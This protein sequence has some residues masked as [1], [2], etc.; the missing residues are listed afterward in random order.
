M[1]NKF[2]YGLAFLSLVAVSCTKDFEEMNTNKKFP[3]EAPPQ[4]LFANAAK[5]LSRQVVTLNVNM[6]N[7]KLWSQ[8]LTQTT[9]TD[10]GNYLNSRNIPQR[11]WRQM[12]REILKDLNEAKKFTNAETWVTAEDKAA[13]QNRLAIMEIYEVYVYE[14]LTSVFGDVPYSQAHSDETSLPEYT[15]AKTV[16]TDLN[17]RLDAI[18]A[19]LDPAAGS[20]DNGYDNLFGGDVAM[21][22]K[23]V[24]GM[25]LKMAMTWADVDAAMAT[26]LVGEADGKVF[27]AGEGANFGFMPTAPN[28]NP[29]WEDL[30]NSG[31]HDY[32]AANTIVDT[33]NGL[34]DP[35]IGGYFTMAP[36]TN[37]YIGGIYG[38]SNS[39]SKFSHIAP[40]FKDPTQ[41]T[42]LMDYIEMEFYF[43]EA[44]ARGLGGGDAKTH[45]E[46]AI[47]ASIEMWAPGTDPS[48]YLA[49]PEVAYDAA[50][51]KE[52]IGL[53]AWLGFF[54]RG[55]LGWTSYRRLDHPTLNIAANSGSPTPKRYTYP[56]NEQTLNGA[57]YSAASAAIGGDDLNTPLWW[58]KN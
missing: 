13:Q 53:Q 49:L 8:Y 21:W 18:L 2:I 7:L 58:D 20:F 17:T 41:P 46:N 9:Y 38:G 35:R 14:R 56:V 33:M 22:T 32:V 37:I 15:D 30:V 24:Y 5:E 16:Y 11:E 28:T 43:A 1:K 6:N 51:W 19:K 44:A 52:Q 29:M 10:E 57:N 23:F 25:K 50:K 55:L 31:R 42:I 27:A 4:A 39:F 36:D 48:A 3:T 34:S 12:Y 54:N 26:K 40:S 47:K 45:Y